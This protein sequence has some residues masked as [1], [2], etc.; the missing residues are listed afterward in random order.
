MCKVLLTGATGNLGSAIVRKL[1]SLDYQ[2]I[3]LKRSS[4]NIN[5]ID[6]VISDVVS[7]DI[8][9]CDLKEPFHDNH[10]IDFVIHTSTDYGIE[11]SDIVN[12][13]NSNIKFPVELLE[14]S[15]NHNIK[16]FLNTDT[17]FNINTKCASEYLNA[18]ATSKT[19][20]SQWGALYSNA[21][22]IK[23]I[24]MRLEHIYSPHD[25]QSKFVNWLITECQNNIESIALTKGQQRRD[26]IY[27]DDVVDAYMLVINNASKL[28]SYWYSMG[29][30]RGVTNTIQEISE[31]IRDLTGAQSKLKF[32]DLNYRNNEIMYSCA[33]IDLLTRMGWKAKYNL[34]SGLKQLL[35]KESTR[36]NES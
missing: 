35:T 31:L 33:N 26:F 12:V 1:L 25:S 29:V 18:Y 21:V 7:Y 17:Y 28:N 11:Q 24:N 32:G 10:D 2:V 16:A 36:F 4:S 23:F 34:R 19:H 9:L 6:D 22:K 13:F 8:D 15:S 14:L 20:F 5:K 27:I 3:I 30:G